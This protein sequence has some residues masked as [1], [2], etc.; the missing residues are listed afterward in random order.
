MTV[1][2]TR[3]GRDYQLIKCC[4]KCDAGQE[5][6]GVAKCIAPFKVRH[7]ILP[8]GN[9]A[10]AYPATSFKPISLK[11]ARVLFPFLKRATEEDDWP[12]H[13]R[14]RGIE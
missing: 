14:K 8:E 13:L 6:P 9:S 3:R 1:V 11:R 4:P 10:Q 5:C 12:Y 7:I 2:T